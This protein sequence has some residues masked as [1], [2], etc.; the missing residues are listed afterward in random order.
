MDEAT[1]RS[2]AFAVDGG[3]V[4]S[5]GG[6]PLIDEDL[7]AGVAAAIAAPAAADTA[8]MEPVFGE[9]PRPTPPAPAPAPAAS[10]PSPPPLF[11][12][13]NIRKPEYW[14][15]A[16][17]IAPAPGTPS[18][19]KAWT[20]DD[21]VGI[22]C[23]RCARALPYQKGSSQSIRYHMETK[24]LDALHEFRQQRSQIKASKAARPAGVGGLA[25]G[26]A[27]SLGMENSSHGAKRKAGV[28]PLS[29][30]GSA[31]PPSF[32][33]SNG[34]A[35]SASTTPSGP[36]SAP[37]AFNSPAAS[38]LA[39]PVAS[40]T[41]ASSWRKNLERRGGFWGNAYWYD[42]Q[43]ERRMPLAKPMLEELVLALPPCDGK[44]VLDLC[45]GS[46]RASAALL[47]AYPTAR[48]TLVDS[49]EQR[50]LMARQRLEALRCG[51][52][53]T[54]QFVTRF[55]DPSDMAELSSEPV[56]VVVACLAFHVLAEKPAHYASTAPETSASPPRLMTVEA[57]YEQLFRATW[58][59]LRPGGHVVF[60]D[61]VGQLPLFQQLKILQQAGFEDVD[62]AW[63]QGDSVLRRAGFAPG[64]ASVVFSHSS[65][66]VA[67]GG[68]AAFYS[69]VLRCS[70]AP[71]HAV[72]V[73]PVNL[74]IGLRVLPA[75]HIFTHEN[76]RE[77]QFFRVAAMSGGVY[78]DSWG[79]GAAIE[80]AASSLDPRFHGRRVLMLPSAVQTHISPRDGCCLFA[81]GNTA[82]ATPHKQSKPKQPKTAHE[83]T[84]VELL[85]SEAHAVGAPLVARCSILTPLAPGAVAAIAAIEAANNA[86]AHA[87]QYQSRRRLSAAASSSSA[88]S[89]K[90]ES[91]VNG[92]P[93]TAAEAAMDQSNALVKLS[94]RGDRTLALYKD[95]EMVALG[96]QEAATDSDARCQSGT[97]AALSR[98]LLDVACGATHVVATSEQGYLLTWGDASEG[99]SSHEAAPTDLLGCPKVVH[100]LLHKRVVQ[101]ACG[102]QHSFALA[103]GGDVFSWGYGGSGA[104]GHGL[105]ALEQ[106]FEAVPSPMEVL[107]LKGRRVVQIA[108]GDQH[109][110]VLLA[111]GELLTCGQREY[112]RLGRQAARK[113][114]IGGD[115][116]EC[117]SWFEPVAFP[118]EG[119]RCT[120]VACGAAH[121][122]A[123]GDSL[124]LYAFGWNASGQLGLGDC[125]DRLVPSRVTYFDAVAS[126]L[127][128]LIVVSVA[129]GKLH[130]LAA[131]PDGRLFAWGSDE[132]GQCG[133]NSCPQIYTVPH[134]VS[135]LVGLRVTQLAA[136]EAHSTVITNGAQRHLDAL[137]LSQPAQYAQLEEF[138]ELAVKDDRKRRAW[139]LEH[140]KRRQLERA[141]AARQRKPSLDPA[142]M[143]MTKMLLLQSLVEEDVAVDKKRSQ[144]RRPHT[145]RVSSSPWRDDGEEDGRGGLNTKAKRP[146]R[147]SRRRSGG[148]RKQLRVSSNV[149]L[150]ELPTARELSSTLEPEATGEAAVYAAGDATSLNQQDT[151][152]SPV[153]HSHE[154]QR[155]AGTPS[156][157]D[158]LLAVTV[159]HGPDSS[160]TNTRMPSDVPLQ[161]LQGKRVDLRRWSVLVSDR[162]LQRLAAHNRRLASS[163]Q[164]AQRL[165]R[166][167][168]GRS[169]SSFALQRQETDEAPADTR[170]QP[171]EALLLTGADTITDAGVAAIALVMPEL[172]ELALAGAKRVTDAALRVLSEHCPR[173]ERLDASALPG[174]RGA[175]LAALVD[176]CGSTLTRLALAD[177]PQLDEWVLRRCFY[178]SPKLTHLD[179]A[180]CPQVN[181]ALLETLAAQCPL[182]RV[183]V[184]SSCLRISDCGIIRVAQ[185]C[186][187]LERVALDRPVGVRGNEPLTDTTCGA[188]G[189][190][191]RKLRDVSLAGCSALTDAGVQWLAAGCAQLTRLDLTGALDLT[192]AA[193]AALGSHCPELR[194]LRLGGVKGVSDVGLR[195]L[196]D[197]CAKLE[198]LHATNLYL[199]SDGSNRD[200]GLEGL[201]AIAAG[202]HE[203]QELN[204][205]GCFQL[206]ERAL[207]AV[208]A[209]CPALRRLNLQACP[210]VTLAAVTAVLRGCQ[211]LARLDLSGM[212]RCD[213]RVL[214]AVAKHG[215][216]L[217]HLIVVGCERVGDAGLHHLA[218]TRADQLELLDLSGCVQVSDVGVNALCEA[219]QRPR[220]AH[221]LL[222]DCPLVTQDAVERLAFVCPLLL[223]LSVH[224]CQISARALKSLSSSWPF[225]ELRLPLAGRA[226]GGH[227][228][229]GFFPVPRASDRRFVAEFC[230][231]WA[232]AACIQNLYRA[233]VARRQALVRR[234]EAT[235]HAVA[236]RLQSLWRGRK[237][238]REAVLRRLLAS[239][240]E[241]SAAL[242]QRRYRAVRRARRVKSQRNDVHEKLL[243]RAVQ[244]TQ[245]RYR[246]LRARR[247]AQSLVDKR[248]REFVR[249]TEAA[250]QLQR[251]FRT[252]SRRDKL[253]LLQAQKLARVRRERSASVQIQRVVRGRLGRL[254]AREL[255]EQLRRFLE[256]QQRCAVRV[257]TQF[258]RIH[259][260]R[261]VA[262]R[263][264]AIL[265]RELAATKLQTIFRARRGRQDVRF[266]ALARQQREQDQAARRVQ[267]CW[268][269]GHDR[270]TLVVM[271]EARRIRNQL[272]SEAAV[273][274]QRAVRKFLLRRRARGMVQ[275]LLAVQHRG[276][277]M[278]RWASTLVQAHWRRR[279]AC[280]HTRAVRKAQRTRWKQLVDTHNH[281]GAG[282]G[283]PFYYRALFDFYGRRRDYG[284][285]AFPSI[286]PTEIL[287]D[288]ARGYDFV[289]L[290][291]R[292]NY[293]AMLWDI[294]QFEPVATGDWDDQ[295]ADASI[296]AMASSSPA[297]A[298]AFTSILT[299]GSSEVDGPTHHLLYRE[300]DFDENG[301]SLWESFYDYAQGGYRYYH[302]VSKRVV[303][304]A[305]GQEHTSQY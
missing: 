181:D 32:Q 279:L 45:A 129:A 194:A 278:Q 269:V 16:K 77:P 127:S 53:T 283:A 97:D 101:V 230:A 223:T 272:V 299:G 178:A 150:Q 260:L 267:H 105:N 237:A 284:D 50:L 152:R 233:R 225:G 28:V 262:R 69:V 301:A 198:L 195:L 57:T 44:H 261:E 212:R 217:R 171:T 42:L 199:V 20:T 255:R 170:M 104:L 139:V 72:T 304:Y 196:A 168:S 47:A 23:L 99:R 62:C 111:C 80:H 160:G 243:E 227:I 134:L 232:A 266:L 14:Q 151:E 36:S 35:A 162:T 92:G 287:Q 185:R 292:N 239:R 137:E 296:V 188:L 220:L 15:F 55:V 264:Q 120:F 275:E 140:A 273:V 295:L 54:A 258:R 136:G 286:W 66:Q 222:A 147:C 213:D 302:R 274:V 38:A 10:E 183:L 56:D 61:H 270:L 12:Q 236:R 7:A 95:G 148:T 154:S 18:G 259:A 73:S 293:Q 169:R 177:C 265:D 82:A 254:Q 146:I 100:A 75:L 159:E 153:P 34:T 89:D 229:T 125:R 276:L 29:P 85:R 253:R 110:A 244:I 94:S 145:A 68:V 91:A 135:S 144:M 305:P 11:S 289:A 193:C 285:G 143:A 282:N 163:S 108:C 157:F 113:A 249:E 252:R 17:L 182:L 207:M 21:A 251:R 184:L 224:G 128:P 3:A 231:S 109:T 64:V 250:I 115:D 246:A 234:E 43:L 271:G 248:R 41:D 37:L 78:D 124:Q 165:Q 93:A 96:V 218:A 119:T 216:A 9:M 31:G 126:S 303:T 202:C 60:A 190:C 219:F 63:R 40:S 90:A 166:L 242:I 204:L 118:S 211:R 2:A 180:R 197:G 173:L 88:A 141:V 19:K 30:A 27:A 116:G 257:Q 86:V 114:A 130:S 256:L 39:P 74:P 156:A 22:W 238:R 67:V 200:F 221:L 215:V 277:E 132:M 121:T 210:D 240:L 186:P 106:A 102:A 155:Q 26:N 161:L 25:A 6:A 247:V 71:E 209:S 206:Q 189:D 138:Y 175:G 268:R 76:W 131:A 49:S 226:A 98:M 5:S 201:R 122:L 103:E 297:V 117:S 48:L 164:Q 214:R 300:Q 46:G 281:H 1:T 294:S 79:G 81:T 83:F 291:P 65:V 241:H 58:R 203:L 172:K 112:G 192:D 263:R 191:C 205:S 70:S 84:E 167:F 290:A 52:S 107:A 179:L 13:S 158:W 149:K 176:R 142:R 298:L 133:L 33:V 288:A 4:A 51:A 245:R 208:G 235:R 24:H 87:A 228:E 8:G 59:V 187:H 123:L 280:R 174:M